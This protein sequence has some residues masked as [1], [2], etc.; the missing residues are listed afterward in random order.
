MEWSGQTH[1]SV[2]LPPAPVAYVSEWAQ[3]SA[4]TLWGKKKFFA[5]CP[6]LELNLNP[7]VPQFIAYS[8]RFS[9]RWLWKSTVF[10]DITPCSPLEANRRFGETYHLH[11]LSPAFKLISCSAYL[12]LKMKPTCSSETSVDFQQTTRRYT[13]EN[14]ALYSLYWL[15]YPVMISLAIK[16]INI[17]DLIAQISR[18]YLFLL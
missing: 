13:P 4:R 3:E 7:W 17:C 16:Y 18:K 6:C 14:S 11:V 10:W 8:F 5:P 9:Q 1:A 2:V 15:S 12:T